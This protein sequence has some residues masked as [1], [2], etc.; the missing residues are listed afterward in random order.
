MRWKMPRASTA[1]GRRAWQTKSPR[2]KRRSDSSRQ[3]DTPTWRRSPRRLKRRRPRSRR[4]KP[5]PCAPRP[6]IPP[7]AKRPARGLALGSPA[8]EQGPGPGRDTEDMAP[9]KVPH[10]D[11]KKLGPPA[12]ARVTVAKGSEAALGAA[13]GDDLEA[14]IAHLHTGRQARP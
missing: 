4:R 10:V 11:T 8:G 9:A 1:T 14:P 12:L 5:Q 13:L 7:P 2:S 3:R 6:P